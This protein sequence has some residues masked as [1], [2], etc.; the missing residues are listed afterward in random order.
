VASEGLVALQAAADGR[1]ASLVEVNSETDFAARNTLFRTLCTSVSRTALELAQSA[2]AKGDMPL[3]SLQEAACVD[4]TATGN[5]VPV[6][7]AV[8]NV[9]ST[10]RENVQVRRVLDS[11][12]SREWWE[13]MC[14]TQWRTMRPLPR[15]DRPCASDA[16]RRSLRW[17]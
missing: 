11:R 17:R 13:P 9:V 12:C 16:R 1:A 4:P 14:T 3:A 7:S 2:A 6:S 5:S 8:T 15:R 10:L